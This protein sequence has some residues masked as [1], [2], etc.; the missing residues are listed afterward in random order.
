[1]RMQ[2]QCVARTLPVMRKENFCT[3][4]PLSK[5]TEGIAA[6]LQR[7]CIKRNSPD[8]GGL[9]SSAQTICGTAANLSTALRLDAARRLISAE[10]RASVC[11]RWNNFRSAVKHGRGRTRIVLRFAF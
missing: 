2:T 5:L 8:G 6:A 4:E 10:W 9:S 3:A 11:W 7:T 1:M